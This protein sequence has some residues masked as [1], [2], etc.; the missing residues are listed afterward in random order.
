MTFEEALL[1]GTSVFLLALSQTLIDGLPDDLS[2]D[3]REHVRL[4]APL[5][6]PE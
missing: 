1:S 4:A 5:A 6:V 2:D 3:Q